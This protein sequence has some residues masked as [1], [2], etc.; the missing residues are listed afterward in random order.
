MSK[1][2]IVVFLLLFCA[3]IPVFAQENSPRQQ[4]QNIR[5]QVYTKILRLTDDEANRFWPVFDE[6]QAKLNEIKKKAKIE[7]L[8]ISDNY[9]KL[10]DIQMEH[11]LDN[12]LEYQ[13]QSL[14]IQKKY[15]QKFKKLI[16]IKKVALL[17]NAEREFKKELL[18][19]IQGY[20]ES[21][22]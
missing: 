5:I 12:L 6:M 9:D 7:R 2:C 20:K 22:E 11:S 13:Q 17:P 14:D 18:K 21:D 10:T 3:K 15:Y 4:V 16:P 8:N 1:N 19:I